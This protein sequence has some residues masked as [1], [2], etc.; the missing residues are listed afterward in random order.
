[1]AAV[2]LPQL[3]RNVHDWDLPICLRMVA[4]LQI[5]KTAVLKTFEGQ[6]NQE[7]GEFVVSEACNWFV[8][9]DDDDLVD[10]G[11][12]VKAMAATILEGRPAD[13]RLASIFAGKL[14]DPSRVAKQVEGR[15][16]EQHFIGPRL[17]FV[18]PPESLDELASVY[19]IEV[20]AA[21]IVISYP[22]RVVRPA[23]QNNRNRMALQDAQQGVANDDDD[24]NVDMEDFRV[25]QDVALS[26]LGR[27]SI[28][29]P[30]KFWYGAFGRGGSEQ[31]PLMASIHL[32]FSEQAVFFH[33]KVPLPEDVG[34]LIGLWNK[35]VRARANKALRMDIVKP[36]ATLTNKESTVEHSCVMIYEG[37]PEALFC[38]I[39]SFHFSF[40]TFLIRHLTQYKDLMNLSYEDWNRS[41]FGRIDHH[42]KAFYHL[43]AN[44]G[45]LQEKD[46]NSLLDFPGL[47]IVQLKGVAE[48]PKAA[49]VLTANANGELCWTCEQPGHLKA[50]CP[51]K[52]LAGKKGGGRGGGNGAGNGGGRGG[53]N[54][55]GAG[56]GG[57]HAGA[58]AQ[59]GGNK[60]KKFGNKKAKKEGN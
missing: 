5:V 4:R 45:N 29:L 47:E 52:V 48:E 17:L 1:M 23:A 31:A 56:T 6:S 20:D 7:A 25:Q 58:K 44:D 3:A 12:N 32:L 42:A 21:I 19:N 11:R 27:S 15:P 39:L 59:G 36:L 2:E 8:L 18:Y 51:N 16:Y 22:N 50:N 34:K 40:Y 54:G 57:G 33:K 14:L 46:T 9:E 43:R 49:T 41:V 28:A 37:I 10:L 30:Y 26:H 60:N 24:A 53:G 35:A 13:T 38:M 55:G